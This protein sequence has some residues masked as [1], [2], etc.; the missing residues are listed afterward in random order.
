M[1]K[2]THFYPKIDCFMNRPSFSGPFQIQ[3]LKLRFKK[4]L[5]SFLSGFQLI[6]YGTVRQKNWFRRDAVES[7]LLNGHFSIKI[8]AEFNSLV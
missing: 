5:K 4:R 8:E 7:R 2:S 3:I 6:S 1:S